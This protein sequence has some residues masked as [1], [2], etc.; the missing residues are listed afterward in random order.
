MEPKMFT[1]FARFCF[2]AWCAAIAVPGFAQDYQGPIHILVGYAPGGPADVAARIVADRLGAELKQ[3]I[4]VENKPGAGGQIAAKALKG[5]PSD[6]STLFLSN[7]HTVVTVPLTTKEPGFAPSK[8]F[9][10]VGAVASF[11][12]AIAVHPKTAAS[13]LADLGAWLGANKAAATIGVPAPASVPEFMALK[14]NHHFHVETVPIPYRGSAP[15]V[16]DLVGGQLTAAVAGIADFLPHQQAGKIKIVAVTHTTPLLPG[17]PSFA[18]SGIAGLETTE[19]LGLFAPAGTSDKT[20]QRYNAA[21][22]RV[23]VAPETRERFRVQ[24]MTPIP[25]TPQAQANELA[26]ATAAITALIKE[27]GFVPQ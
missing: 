14:I 27:S 20:I 8:D 21:L 4:I 11:E 12:L 16:T 25:G 1:S 26:R 9:R 23:L 15:L 24:I 5:S 10:P 17:V 2:V 13:N 22:N 18:E 7:L 3:T 19:T 6:G